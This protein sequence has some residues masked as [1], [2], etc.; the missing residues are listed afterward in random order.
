MQHGDL[1]G[2]NILVDSR[3]EPVVIDYGELRPLLDEHLA[4]NGELL[5]YIVF[6]GDFL[7][8]FIDR[9]RSGDHE[10]ARRSWKPLS[11]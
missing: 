10:P 2:L 8:W 7:P 3:G 5:S 4:D 1:H 9:V 11:R 6:E